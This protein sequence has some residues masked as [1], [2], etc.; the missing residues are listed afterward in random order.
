MCHMHG[1]SHVSTKAFIL[2]CQKTL[3]SCVLIISH[4]KTLTKY[5]LM[6]KQLNKYICLIFQKFEKTTLL[7]HKSS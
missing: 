6:L 1:L 5:I 2:K 3:P 7:K 4:I